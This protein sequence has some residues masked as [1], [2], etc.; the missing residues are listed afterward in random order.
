MTTDAAA[1]V[2]VESAIS[3]QCSCCLARDAYAACV[4]SVVKATVRA[5][6]PPMQN[7]ISVGDDDVLNESLPADLSTVWIDRD[8]SWLDF[9]D[10][11]LAQALDSRT[12]LLERVKFLAIFGSNLDE[13]FMKRIAVLRDKLTPEKIE[14]LERIRAKLLPSLALQAECFRNTIVPG[15][16]A[17]GIAFARWHDLSDTQKE[18]AARYFTEQVSP[19]L[20]P[21]VIDPAHPFPFLSNLSTSLAFSLFDPTRH[22]SKYGRVKV[23]GVLRQWVPISVDGGSGKVL[24]ALHEIIRG[25]LHKLYAGMEFGGVTL[26]RVTRDAE[27]ELDEDAEDESLAELVQE[28]V[29]RRRYE[30]IVRLEFARGADTELREVLCER[31]QLRPFDV[32]DASEE[33]DYTS[34]FELASMNVESQRD[35]SW[36]PITPAA[37]VREDAE[38]FT[39][40]RERDVLVHH[41][42]ESFNDT[43]E[44]FVAA[45]ANDPQ[46]VAVKMTVYRIGDDTPFV[47][48]LIRAA[49]SGKQVACIIEIKAR[50][51]EERN[52]L[53]AAELEK[54]GAHVTYGVRGLKTHAKIILVVRKED[55]GLRRYA[56]VGTGNYHVKTAKLYTDAGLFTCNPSITREVVR[57]F[58]CLTGHSQP[59]PYETL[60]VAPVTMR[61]R[62]LA[63]IAREISNLQG[64]RPARIV[65][66]MNQLEDPELIA[67]LVEAACAGVP[68]DLIVR[69]FCCLRAGVPG[70]TEGIRVRSIVGRFLEH[71]RIFH[72]AAGEKNPAEG[73]FYIGSADWMKRNL[74]SR[75]EVVTPVLVPFLKERL[76]EVLDICLRDCRQAWV[77]KSDGSYESLQPEAEGNGP[78][79]IGTHQYLMDLT[80]TRAAGARPNTNQL[81]EE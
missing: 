48:S 80:A 27:V 69:G 79:T 18:E 66:K 50:F 60:L 2:S 5:K 26:F 30:P 71:S 74:S 42:Y 6:Q 28:Q 41:P 39:I 44:R 76:W 3:A 13:F 16:A 38:V 35:R 9:N 53:W 10:R 70:I 52:L 25:N 22:E 45:A 61:R 36:T 17:H 43:V 14:L 49:E 62:F 15:L 11:V 47:Q 21:L 65:A 73:E 33:L 40:I 81:A 75:I 59:P 34:L 55:G 67:A 54:A 58:H 64:G 4:A 77:M 23:P 57:I 72:F 29:R 24:V 37:F 56:H 78:E 51:D 8:L 46:T 68:V 20:T 12:P 32:Y 19:A 63:M 1:V 7:R 31:F